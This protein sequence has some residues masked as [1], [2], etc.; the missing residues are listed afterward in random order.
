MTSTAFQH[1]VPEPIKQVL[2][3]SRACLDAASQLIATR[4][5]RGGTCEH[6]EYSMGADMVAAIRKCEEVATVLP[7]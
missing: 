6:A 1:T 5:A 4:L 7:S 3:L 2:V